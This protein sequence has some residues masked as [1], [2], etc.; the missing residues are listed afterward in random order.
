[1]AFRD[2]ALNFT[3]SNEWDLGATLGSG[4]TEYAPDVITLPTDT[5][6]WDDIA[7]GED[8]YVAIHVTEDFASGGSAGVRF[9]VVLADNNAGLNSYR[10]GE[11][12][13]FSMAELSS[14]QSNAD[15][16]GSDSVGLLN[17]AKG[18]AGAILMTL[19]PLELDLDDGSA[20]VLEGK[21]LSLRAVETGSAALTQGKVQAWLTFAKDTGVQGLKRFHRSGFTIS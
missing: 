14:V 6:S 8:L 18:S 2:I 1:M 20:Q 4:D 5:Q 10:I 13:N 3:K 11:T 9:E 12:K 15:P 16:D 19:R 17:S 7:A 21:F